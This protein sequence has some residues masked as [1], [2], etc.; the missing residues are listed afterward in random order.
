[1][2]NDE[3]NGGRTTVTGLTAYFFRTT[4]VTRDLLPAFMTHGT[5]VYSH[6]R[7]GQL[8]RAREILSLEIPPAGFEPEGQ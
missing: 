2:M 6:M 4:I 3:G 8:Y 5:S 1:M 7:E